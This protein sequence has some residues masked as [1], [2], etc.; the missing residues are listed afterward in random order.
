MSYLLETKTKARLVVVESD[1]PRVKDALAKCQAQGLDALNAYLQYANEA[2][3]PLT[4]PSSR[5]LRHKYAQRLSRK[6][7]ARGIRQ[8]IALELLI[9]LPKT[10]QSETVLVVV[11]SSKSCKVQVQTWR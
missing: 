4:F 7:L 10:P 9:P 11:P 8:L 3:K 2:P 5:Q 6:E 1:S